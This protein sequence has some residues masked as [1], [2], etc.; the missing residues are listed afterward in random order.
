LTTFLKNI[1]SGDGD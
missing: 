1:V